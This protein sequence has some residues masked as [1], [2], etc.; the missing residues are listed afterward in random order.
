MGRENRPSPQEMGTN[1]DEEIT[2]EM[3]EGSREYLRHEVEELKKT[4]R[5]AEMN[6]GISKFDGSNEN[7]IKFAES[8]DQA[9]QKLR[10]VRIQLGEEEPMSEEELRVQ[11]RISQLPVEM[12]AS[13]RGLDPETRRIIV[14]DQGLI[15]RSNEELERL[16]E[17]MKSD[18]GREMESRAGE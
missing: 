6:F 1:E 15:D 7:D 9:K 16:F 8:I 3:L 2:D 14:S 5:M 13:F 4:L 11:D 17:K 12:R 10:E 18:I